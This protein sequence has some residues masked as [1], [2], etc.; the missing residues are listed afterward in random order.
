[1][2]Q[3]YWCRYVV[4]SVMQFKSYFLCVKTTSMIND[5]LFASDKA[6]KLANL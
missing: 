2:N 5:V 3:F 6:N 4:V 1:M